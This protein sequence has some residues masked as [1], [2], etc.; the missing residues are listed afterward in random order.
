MSE[1]DR[2][3]SGVHVARV[4]WLRSGRK[5]L[6]VPQLR[7][8]QWL[9][10]WTNGNVPL[11]ELIV[12]AGAADR[13]DPEARLVETADDYVEY[14]LAHTNRSSGWIGPFLNEPGDANGHGLWDP[15]YVSYAKYC[16]IHFV[17]NPFA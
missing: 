3:L 5:L 11:K 13:L 12:A 15:L 8:L 10:Y 14:I 2:R 9:P 1:K 4:R 16:P 6:D 17:H 7:R